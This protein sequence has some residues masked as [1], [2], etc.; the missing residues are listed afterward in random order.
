M[1][2]GIFRIQPSSQHQAQRHQHSLGQA[3]QRPL[4]HT[5]QRLHANTIIQPRKTEWTTVSHPCSNKRIRFDTTRQLLRSA[6][7]TSTIYAL[8][9]LT[10]NLPRR[11]KCQAQQ[12]LATV[13]KKRKL[14]SPQVNKPVYVQPLMHSTF[15][16]DLRYYLKSQLTTHHNNLL[17]L[18]I[19][20]AKLVCKKNTHRCNKSYTIGEQP[21]QPGTHRIH[22]RPVARRYNAIF[23]Y[24]TFTSNM[25]PY[26]LHINFLHIQA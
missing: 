6:T 15:T 17:P 19:P 1:K 16:Q 8:H 5:H 11:D 2:G 12:A 14:R 26:T 23:Q 21:T 22:P 3:T 9:K 4:S 25:L 18:H 24:N 7:P 20:S 13:L 10:G